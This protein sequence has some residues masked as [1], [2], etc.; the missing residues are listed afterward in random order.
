MTSEK[1]TVACE[2]GCT[3][4]NKCNYNRHLKTDKHK[5]ML[6]NGGDY[7]TWTRIAGRMQAI[8]GLQYV[9]RSTDENTEK[10]KQAKRT[11]SSFK[12]I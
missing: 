10:Y 4:R 6:E 2:C 11:W 1:Q 8:K 9:I 7:K 3:I 12:T 5:I